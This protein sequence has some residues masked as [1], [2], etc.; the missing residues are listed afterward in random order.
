MPG[1]F[2]SISVIAFDLDG[3]DQ[4]AKAW[5]VI[6]GDEAVAVEK[7]KELAK[8]HAGALVVKREGHPAVGEEGDP[9]IVFQTGR[10]G[11]FV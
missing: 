5:E 10:I 3:S 7:A 2:T 11:D 9:V 6:V 4:P 1:A 8:D